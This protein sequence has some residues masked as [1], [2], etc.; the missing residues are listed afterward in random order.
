MTVHSTAVR[1]ITG[2]A[3]GNARQTGQV[4]VFGSA[5]NAVDDTATAVRWYAPALV[6]LSWR[7]VVVKA[8]YALGDS[9]TPVLVALLT[10][11]SNVPSVIGVGP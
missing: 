7:E 5:P 8:S 4:C 6:A 2:S 1:L 10:V 9:R 3:P 11:Q